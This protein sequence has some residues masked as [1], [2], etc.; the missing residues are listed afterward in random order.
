M[1]CAVEQP[2]AAQAATATAPPP[3]TTTRATV[4]TIANSLEPAPSVVS[5]EKPRAFSTRITR[6]YCRCASSMRTDIMLVFLSYV[7]RQQTSTLGFG[8]EVGIEF[9]VQGPVSDGGWFRSERLGFPVA[10]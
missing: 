5:L 3:T 1:C 4:A 7:E 6:N 9:R 8:V 10:P 2:L